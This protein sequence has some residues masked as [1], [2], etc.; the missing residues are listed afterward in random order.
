MTSFDDVLDLDAVAQAEAVRTGQLSPAELVEA[1]IRR[2]EERN[3]ALNAVTFL[4]AEGALVAAQSNDL[5][6]GKFRG[7][8]MLMKDLWPSTAGHPFTLGNQALTKA[9][10]R[11]TEDA[12]ITRAYKAAGFVIL[13]R[14]NTPELGLVGTTEPLSHGPTRNPCN[15]KHSSGGSSGGAASAVASAMV[16]VANASDGGGSIRIPASSCGLVGLKPSRGVVSMG[17]AQ[18]EW[19]VS[20]QHVVSRTVRDSA[21]VLDISART[22]PGDGVI[23]PRPAEGYLAAVGRDPGRLRIGMMTHS[24]TTDTDADCVRAATETAKRLEALGHHVELAHPDGL[25]ELPQ[26]GAQFSTVW[27]VNAAANLDRIATMLGRELTEDDVEPTTWVL[28]SM[29]KSRSGVELAKAFGAMATIRRRLA[30]WW[31]PADA[32]IAGL[33]FDLLLTPTTASPPPPIGALATSKENPMGPFAGSGPLATFTSIW[34]ATGQPAISV[35]AV[36]TADALPIGAQLV[37]AYGA[38][39]LLLSVAA[40]LEAAGL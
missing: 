33:G 25:S 34:N 19:G 12:N 4:D 24:L 23:A 20:V 32:L 7:V 36:V 15:P 2:I 1:T 35:P 31:A 21:A 11:A 28:A 29:G 14:T 17:P 3:P 30:S 38:D 8:P 18:D 40:Q 39:A 6:S 37:G 26:F 13:G 22:F 5:P 16:A 27:A 9:G 10:H